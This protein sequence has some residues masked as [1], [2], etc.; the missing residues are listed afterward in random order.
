[1][2]RLGNHASGLLHIIQADV[3][4]RGDVDDHAAST[5][6]AGFQQ[7]AGNG[8][9]RGVFGL[10]GA[11]GA[12]HA[13]VGV[14]GILH[15]AAHVGKVQVDEGGHVDQC[16]DA[17]HTLAQ[18]VV[19]R[20]KGVGQGDL[21]LADE[22]QPLVGDHNQA[23]HMH[24]QIVDALLGH[25]HLAL[26][27]K[28]EGLGHNAHGENAQIVGHLG[29]HRGSAGAGA[30]AHTGGDKHHLRPLQGAGDLVLALFGGTL[31]HLGVGACAAALGQLCAQL[32][33]LGGL[34]GQQRL[35]VGVHGHKLHALHA[36]QQHAVHG[37]AAAAAHADY[38]DVGYIRHLR[39]KHKSHR[40]NIPRSVIFTR[41]QR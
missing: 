23:V 2:G 30:A 18:H 41:I 16:R 35:L 5:G 15:D 28:R 11:L 38:L 33:L 12:A 21:L 29:H 13:H 14:T 37:V 34:A 40:S 9:L 1:M 6:N 39:I 10:S 24:Q 8:G 22:L 3:R 20:G 25:V 36:V 17:L 19:R 4:R 31:A 7:R 26:A 32:Y 27:L